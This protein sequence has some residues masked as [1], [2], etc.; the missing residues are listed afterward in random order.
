MK[1]YKLIALGLCAVMALSAVPALAVGTSPEDENTVDYVDDKIRDLAPAEGGE[2]MVIAPAPD[3][4]APQGQY[5]L[6]VDG[7]ETGVSI[8]VAVPLRT[9]AEALGFEVLWNGDG[10]VTVD[11]GVMHCD[12]IIGEDSYQVVTS[13]EELVGMSAP[14]SL[15]MAPYVVNGS[16]YV[17]LELFSILLG[18]LDSARISFG[19]GTL[20][21]AIQS[22][23]VEVPNPFAPCADLKEA[24]ELTGFS[25]TVPSTPDAVEVMDG[26]MIE[27]R[28][29]NGMCIRKAAGSED[30][31]GDYNSYA[32]V[33]TVDGVTLKGE[34]GAFTLAVWTKDGYTYSVSLEKT[35]SQ[36]DLLALAAKVQ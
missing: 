27:A 34:D 9:M 23:K 32:Q 19:D 8:P 18:N 5:S 33:K 10:T 16:T 21:L 22:Q 24:A 4:D 28:W 11:D 29:G 26:S 17:P 6:V 31:S 14:F 13:N 7:R 15:G 25:L 2:P 30:V 35:L 1:K 12:L 3:F 36:A 20:S